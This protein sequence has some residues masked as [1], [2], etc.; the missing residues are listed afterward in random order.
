LKIYDVL[1]KEVGILVNQNLE[2]GTYSATWEASDLSGG[3]YFYKLQNTNFVET[4]KMILI[5]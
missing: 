4:R 1:G 2:P 3:I 5:K